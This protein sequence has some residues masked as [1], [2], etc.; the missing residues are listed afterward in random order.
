M[1][2]SVTFKPA[3]SD[4]FG[5]VETRRELSLIAEPAAETSSWP[6]RSGEVTSNYTRS[7]FL[8]C[9]SYELYTQCVSIVSMWICSILT[10]VRYLRSK[11]NDD[12][13]SAAVASIV[14][15][16][17]AEARRPALTG[18]WAALLMEGCRTE[19]LVAGG[20]Q[21]LVQY[22]T[23]LWGVGHWAGRHHVT[24]MKHVE[25]WQIIWKSIKIY[26]QKVYKSIFTRFILEWLQY[27]THPYQFM[28]L[29]LPH[30]KSCQESSEVMWHLQP[31]HYTHRPLY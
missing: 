18:V 3:M 23:H 20:E 6:Q 9:Q 16:C 8:H 30:S 24:H 25:K 21:I 13:E 19:V 31:S 22:V 28:C 4:V 14:G 2:S 15:Q 5:A 11:V 27:H 7:H 10:T 29:Q 12:G 26:K 17:R 1:Y